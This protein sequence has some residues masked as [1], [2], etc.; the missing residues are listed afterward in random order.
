M[1]NLRL[2][3]ETI[4]NTSVASVNVTDVFSSDFDIYKITVT[5]IEVAGDSYQNMRFINSSGS[6]VSAS[7]YDDA[8][9]GVY[10]FTSFGEFKGVNSTEFKYLNYVYPAGYDDGNGITLYVF[11]PFNS[12]SYTFILYQANGFAN[13]LNYMYM[14]KSIGVLKQT[15]SITGFSLF[16]TGNIDNIKIRT[17][18]LRVDS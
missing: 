15:S 11:N 7:S 8:G 9:L 14:F 17:Y 1:S 4:S 6:I 13:T 3:N 2:I 12:S 16:K 18:G 5:D 10:S